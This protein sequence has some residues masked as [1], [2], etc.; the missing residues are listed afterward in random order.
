[1]QHN[2]IPTA[3]GSKDDLYEILGVAANADDVVIRAG[4]TA[5]VTQCEPGRFSGSPDDAQR[6]LSELTA[7]YELL[8]DPQ[9]RRRYDLQRRIHAMTATMVVTQ[10]GRYG[11]APAL[12]V[13]EA[14]PPTRGRPYY[15]SRTLLIAVMLLLAAFALVY[16]G[17]LTDPSE[18]PQAQVSGP[19]TAAEP[20]VAAEAPVP[21][22]VKV[23]TPVAE[24]QA[25]T[26]QP[27]KPEPPAVA[28]KL[29]ANRAGDSAPAG[30]T[31]GACT[32]VLTALG[33]C[34]PR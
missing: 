19:P 30:A 8:S 28:P 14:S 12:A 1:M 32:D 22:A 2:S 11:K 23:P 29:P 6:R 25:P 18:A 17:R 16:S 9:R 4:Y 26:A 3:D 33:L 20:A 5:L 21:S 24:H 31:P 15:N 7:A 13:N 10:P 27:P 34:K